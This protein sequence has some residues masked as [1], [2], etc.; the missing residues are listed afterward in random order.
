MEVVRTTSGGDLNKTQE[1]ARL[2]MAPGT[3]HC[4]MRTDGFFDAVVKWVE[5]GQAPATVAHQV[6]A[7][8]ARP[9]C[10][11]PTVAVYKGAGSTDD[12][13][14][15]FCGSDQGTVKDDEDAARRGNQRVFGK[16]FLPVP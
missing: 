2:F 3:A 8:M 12:A 4:G 10:P 15:F 6:S 1:F 16:P 5:M 11:H 9:L 13:A 14:N 7:Q